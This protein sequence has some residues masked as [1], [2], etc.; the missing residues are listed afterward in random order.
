MAETTTYT[1]GCH[2]GA[3]R[4]RDATMKLE[5]AMTCNCSICSKTGSML[6][7]IPAAQFELTAG[8]EALTD[9]Q[10]GR[11]NPSPVLQAVRGS[12]LRARHCPRR[13]DGR[14]ERA[15]RGWRRPRRHPAQAVRRE[16]PP[17]RRLSGAG[18]QPR[19]A[20]VTVRSRVRGRHGG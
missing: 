10:W 3:V 8:A 20:W 13:A 1:G 11:E 4:Y 16:E 7:F 2:C 9:Y 12:F 15:V 6:A 19:R 14:T 17:R 18:A 5:S